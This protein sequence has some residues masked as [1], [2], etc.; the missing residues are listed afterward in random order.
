MAKKLYGY[1]S[2]LMYSCTFVLMHNAQIK[3]IRIAV[4]GPES[5]GKSTLTKQLAEVFGGQFIPE[6]AREYIENLPHHYT[7]EDVE[8]IAKAQVEQYRLT[9]ERSDNIFFFDTWLII[10][11]V[12]FNWVFNKMPEWMDIEIRNCPMDLFLLCRPDLPWEADPVRENGG[13]N[14]LKLF[15]LYRGELEHYGFSFVEIGGLGEGRLNNAI[16]AVRSFYKMQ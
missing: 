1:G 10:T 11:K 4:T 16:A 5:T 9:Q 15:E 13:E 2:F 12:W 3:Q 14:R 7:Y 6:F 8:A